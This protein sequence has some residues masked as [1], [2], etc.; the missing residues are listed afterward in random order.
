MGNYSFHKL[1]K[2]QERQLSMSEF[3][4]YREQLRQYE[5]ENFSKIKGIKRKNDIIGSC[6]Q[7]LFWE[8]GYSDIIMAFE[9]IKSPCW[10]FLSDPES[11][12]R[13]FDGWLVET[14]GVIYMNAYSKTD[15]K[16]AKETVIHL[17]Q[18]NGSLL[19]FPEGA[20]NVTDNLPVMKLFRGT[21]EMALKTGAEI[22]PIAI[23]QYRK[24]FYVNI[25]K[26]IKYEC[27]QSDA[28]KLTNALRDILATLK[29][30]I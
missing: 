9:A 20:W 30:K 21:V 7:S 29:W 5:F 27:F 12:Y 11:V 19:I 24:N 15:R 23:E 26:N 13:T 14:N 18:Q 2:R 17:L 10:L 6:C 4:Q 25:G 8:I 16:I 28:Q 3:V 1:N 22:V